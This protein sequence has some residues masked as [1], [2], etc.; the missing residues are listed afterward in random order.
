MYHIPTI[1]PTLGPLDT[2]E[3]AAT[4][5]AHSF[6]S[7]LSSKSP[8]HCLH[9]FS[10]VHNSQPLILQRTV[11]KNQIF[12]CLC[13]IYTQTYIHAQVHVCTYAGMR[14]YVKKQDKSCYIEN[15][16]N[17]L[18]VFGKFLYFFSSSFVD[19]KSGIMLKLSA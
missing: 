13:T 17:N 10:S 2:G 3:S 8:E 11:G 15:Y 18:C 5:A 1:T 6:P 4:G 16:R 9:V 7:I 19:D 12:I 14:S